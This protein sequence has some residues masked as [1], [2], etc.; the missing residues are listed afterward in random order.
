MQ[1]VLTNQ[2]FQTAHFYPSAAQFQKLF[3]ASLDVI[4]SIDAE[5]RFIHVSKA[6]Y[7]IW[8]YRPDE[9][10]GQSYMN[11]VIEEDK[12]K[13]RQAA[14]QIMQG[15]NMTFFENR[16]LRKDGT[17][18][19]VLWSAHWSE[20]EQVMFC[21]ARDATE[22]KVQEAL[23]ASYEQE[24]KRQHTEITDILDRIS[25]GFFALDEQFNIVYGTARA[26]EIIGVSKENYLNRNLFD[27][28]PGIKETVF[29]Q[30]YTRAMRERTP[31]H[32]EE[33]FTP[34]G[35]WYAVHAYPSETGL[36]IFF[37][38]ITSS[39]QADEEIR[40]SHE[41]FELA[42]KIEA[43]YDW[44]IPS[45]ELHW[46]EGLSIF[47]GYHA[48]EMQ[49][50][51]WSQ[52]LHPDDRDRVVEYVRRIL[53]DS[54]ASAMCT[55]YRLRRK[56]GSYAFVHEKGHILRNNKGEA[57]RLVGLMQDVTERKKAET[58]R[59]EYEIRIERKNAQ[60]VN[61]LEGMKEGFFSLDHMFKVLYW[62]QKVAQITGISKEQAIGSYLP[63]LY[64]KEAI[65]F[66]S[67]LFLKALKN[68]TPHQQ[69]LR[70]P[71]NKR[72]I[73]MSIYPSEEG[74]SVFIKDINERKEF[75]EEMR[76]LSLVAKETENGVMI[77]D[78]N[79]KITWINAAF[80][81]MTGY[82]IDDCSGKMPSELLQGPETSQETIDFIR[83][84]LAAAKAFQ[85][86]CINYRKNGEKFWSELHGQPLFDTEGNVQQFFFI[87]K[88]ITQR[89]KLEEELKLQH[90]RTNAAVIAAQE[91]ER[92]LVGREL[93][94][95][96]NQV[97]TS[98][99]LYQDLML[100][101]IG[102]KE[103]LAKKSTQLLQESINEIRSLSKRL[104]APTLGNIKL[105]DSVKELV[106]TVAATN[107]FAIDLDVSVIEEL[108]VEQ[109]V[110]LAIYRIVQEHL[111]N[112]LKY[113][114][115]SRVILSFD[116]EKGN[117][118]LRIQDDGK[119]FDTKEKR[120]GI[121]ITNMVMR[122]E[123]LNGQLNINSRPNQGC[124]MVVKFPLIVCSDEVL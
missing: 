75:E 92:A 121:G 89:K 84:Q 80:T 50:E 119:G 85:V 79:R 39:K 28:F 124:E 44:D 47:F 77:T 103:E 97:L 73:E 8:G 98:V 105:K 19:P 82:T 86:E 59:R 60:L 99:K 56:N 2:N 63:E 43:L 32:F 15:V 111:T 57:I 62:N 12:G 6:A 107:K 96:V 3:D 35:C 52:A 13:T 21:V 17:I 10:F 65:E 100:S 87:R 117:L 61:I 109:E 72:W 66:Y 83:K 49:M 31:V 112:I 68:K 9:L 11:L 93:H 25:D 29:Y 5:G 58:E 23:Q 90:K 22:K 27:C 30:H 94:D 67:P 51:Q 74:C 64:T 101:G 69:E 34:F 1:D 123:S 118:I 54:R 81:R 4:C 36:S 53:L 70:C 113:A 110:H 55:E 41:R 78:R 120:N 114:D 42:A 38:D 26:A 104:S 116:F 122:A 76:K 16:Y 14:E 45:N 33:Y 40:K 24:I 95:N 37:R 48:N 88:D 102:N 106:D 71:Q 46:G 115:A 108:E 91:K 20:E 18:V 7:R